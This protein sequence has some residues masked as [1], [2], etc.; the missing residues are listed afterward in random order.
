MH[1]GSPVLFYQYIPLF[2]L[3]FKGNIPMLHGGLVGYFNEHGIIPGHAVT[4]K[5]IGN[6]LNKRIKLLFLIRLHA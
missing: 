2:F 1:K 5:N 6:G 4:F 3:L